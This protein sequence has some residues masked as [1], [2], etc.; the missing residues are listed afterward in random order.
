LNNAAIIFCCD[1]NG[2]PAVAVETTY[3]NDGRA[4]AK[5]GNGNIFI[6]TSSSSSS[7]HLLSLRLRVAF[8]KT[9]PSVLLLLALK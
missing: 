7:A 5:S 4:A 2:V 9:I 6:P 8:F 1:G 3:M